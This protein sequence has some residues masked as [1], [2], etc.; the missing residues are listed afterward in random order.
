MVGL[1]SDTVTLPLLPR[2]LPRPAT[3]SNVKFV[4]AV[5]RRNTSPLRHL[6]EPRHSDMSPWPEWA[7]IAFFVSIGLGTLL[8]IILVAF[9]C[10][11]R[12]QR[13]GMKTVSQKDVS[14]HESTSTV[15]LPKEASMSYS[16]VPYG[17][18]V[19]DAADDFTP[20]Q[21]T[22]SPTRPLGAQLLS[23]NENGMYDVPLE[24]SYGYGPTNP[25]G[26]GQYSYHRDPGVWR[27]KSQKN[28]GTSSMMSH[29]QSKAPVG[30][31]ESAF[32]PWDSPTKKTFKF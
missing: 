21:Q 27:S 2:I 20:P 6:N 16:Q 3:S 19:S 31:Q 24:T 32:S 17:G 5:I 23:P 7:R 9:L 28:I 29:L 1:S 11:R 30:D 22:L 13:D 12:R 10:S 25:P 14:A 4:P 8:F 15:G 26:P 18:I